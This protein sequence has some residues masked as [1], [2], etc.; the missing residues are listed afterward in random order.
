[1]ATN[2]NL[3]VPEQ[4]DAPSVP[5]PA[6]PS[7]DESLAQLEHALDLFVST[8]D[9]EQFGET[10][11]IAQT[12]A[13][14]VAPKMPVA[15]SA[16]TGTAPVKDESFEQ[17]IRELK[18]KIANPQAA[19][20]P[21]WTG[22]EMVVIPV[23]NE[24]GKPRRF[25]LLTDGQKKMLL[26]AV[27]LVMFFALIGLLIWQRQKTDELRLTADRQEAARL[28]SMDA[29]PASSPA[30]LAA[31]AA[32]AAALPGADQSLGD[33]VR[34]ILLAYNPSAAGS[35]YKVEVKDGVVTLNGEA[36]SQLEKDGVENVIKPLT[37]IRQVVN[38]LVVKGLLPGGTPG[39]MTAPNGPVMYPQVNQAEAKRL[40]EA[41]KR[42]LAE[43]AKRAEEER[44]RI[45]Q[46][47]AQLAA[48]RAAEEAAKQEAAKQEAAKQ[49]A[50]KQE[51]E[52]QRRQQTAAVYNEED[53]A[54]RKQAEDRLKQRE[55]EEAERRAEEQRQAQLKVE[56]M[57]LEPNALRSGT[58]TWRGLVK[59]VD[60]IVIRGAS[61]TVQH[62][63]GELPKDAKGVFSTALPNA[64]ISVRLVAASGP[65]SIRIIQQPAAANNFT[66]IVRV[67]EGKQADGKPHSFTLR[68]ASQ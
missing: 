8:H 12:P 58:V 9:D 59:G 20:A 4:S 61:A 25:P 15:E 47:N 50:A 22:T 32:P 37:G 60:D 64:P 5:T 49:E 41:L 16:A 18:Q 53:A 43:G 65:S 35:R 66:T 38:N 10:H 62:V 45:E 26:L 44:L 48:Q 40:E 23:E 11:V 51:A 7:L 34:Q 2:Q 56:P 36:Q 3:S 19:G 54:F 17:A 29:A 13:P 57:R 68:W 28:R 46:Q 63:S 27:I 14:P 33:N 39:G 30:P 67:G 52:R 24:E 21:P 55:K 6:V 1:M 31:A 42:D